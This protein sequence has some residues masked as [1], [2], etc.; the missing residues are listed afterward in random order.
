VIHLDTSFLIRALVRTSPQD[1]RLRQ[2]LRAGEKLGI[3]AIGWAE[4]LCGPLGAEA[5]ELVARLVP[6][7]VPFTEDEAQ[8]AAGLF[9]A[10]GRRRGT[11]VDCMIAATAIRHGALLATADEKD[12]RKFAAAGLALA[13][14]A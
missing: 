12:F 2:W 13:P 11:L 10:S 7:R 1:R 5:Q 4:F 9:N 14:T 8:L 3:S 6:R